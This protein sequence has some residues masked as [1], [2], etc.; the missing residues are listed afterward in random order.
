EGRMDFPPNVDA[1]LWFVAE[2]LP[3]VQRQRPGVKFWAV[4][5]KPAPEVLALAGDAVT[6]TGWV[7]D[8]RP[9]LDR[10][11]LF[12]APMRMGA[13]IKN[14]VLQAWAMGKAVVATPA[15]IGGLLAEPGANLEVAEGAEALAERIVQLLQDR[16]RR[17]A[18]GRA[19]RAT[20]EAHYTWARRAEALAEVMQ[21]A[22]ARR[23]GR[24]A[25]KVAHA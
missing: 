16:E 21:D 10:A 15:A 24:A 2:V 25:L 20:I 22:V 12:V 17:T 14:K 9:W 11:A 4:G 1:V 5:N 19:A 6:V 23:S 8:V 7:D 18:L 13:G 3:L